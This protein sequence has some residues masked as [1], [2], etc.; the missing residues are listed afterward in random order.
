MMIIM[1]MIM[2][3]MM[4]IVHVWMKWRRLGLDEGN[5]YEFRTSSEISL[6]VGFL[7]YSYSLR[8]CIQIRVTEYSQAN[9]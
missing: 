5:V 7:P 2:M 3:I 6:S 8:Q 4:M 1:I 9:F